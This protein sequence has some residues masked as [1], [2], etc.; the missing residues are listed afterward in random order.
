MA[1]PQLRVDGGPADGLHQA[2]AGYIT[3]NRYVTIRRV[4]TPTSQAIYV[5]GKQRFAHAGDYS[6]INRAVSVFAS[7]GS[8]VTVKSVRVRRL[9]S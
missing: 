8:I 3:P 2:G 7:N 9:G 5:D 6:K 4:V 1:K